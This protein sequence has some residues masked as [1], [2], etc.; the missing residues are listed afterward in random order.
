ML[1]IGT[2]LSESFHDAIRACFSC[3]VSFERYKDSCTI[4]SFW[5]F[6]GMPQV[7]LDENGEFYL[8]RCGGTNV[9]LSLS[10]CKAYAVAVA[11]VS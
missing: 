5:F 1:R 4:L 7:F 8:K 6:L 2:I 3:S 11:A 9:E 10:H